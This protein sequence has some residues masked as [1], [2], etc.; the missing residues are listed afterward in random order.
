MRI[1][2][3]LRSDCDE[4]PD[5]HRVIDTDDPDHVLA[6]GDRVTD[7]DLLEKL[8]IPPHETVVKIQ[9]R[10]VDGTPRVMPRDEWHAWYYAHLTQDHFR[11][12]TLPYYDPDR[13]SFAE[14]QRGDYESYRQ[15]GLSWRTKVR[16]ERDAGLLRRRVRIV[17]GPLTDYERFECQ[18]GYNTLTEYGEEIRILD[19]TV[20]PFPLAPIGDFGVFNGTEVVRMHYDEGGAILGASVVE[21]DVEFFVAVRDML[22]HLAE[23]FPAWWAAHPEHHRKGTYPD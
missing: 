13:I 18:W 3:V 5:C 14:W 20:T 23:P 10:F 8:H 15:R 19:L 4:R 12:E 1:T 7:Q 17:R 2:G 9:R 6:Q 11:L 22:W 16:E 21:R